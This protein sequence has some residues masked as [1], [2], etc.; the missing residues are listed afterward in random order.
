MR[1]P[2]LL[3]GTAVLLGLVVFA[4]Y[5]THLPSLA[6]TNHKVSSDTD[7]VMEQSDTELLVDDTFIYA[8]GNK[9]E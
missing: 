5:R 3:T 1:N 9:P 6:A 2:V 7:M 4:S 8:E